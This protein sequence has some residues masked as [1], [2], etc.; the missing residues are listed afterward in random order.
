MSSDERDADD[1]ES[2]QSA[3]PHWRHPS[4]TD[5]L[6]EIDSIGAKS[7]NYPNSQRQEIRRQS[8]AVDLESRVVKELPINFYDEGYINGLD[9]SQYLNLSP[10]PAVSLEFHGR[11]QS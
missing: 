11:T 8:S 7:M 10:K 6:H 3:R 1:D 5:W 2:F 4:I 9:R